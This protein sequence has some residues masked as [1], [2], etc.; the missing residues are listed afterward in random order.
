[1]AQ[2]SRTG[3]VRTVSSPG[4]KL[5][6]RTLSQFALL[7][8]TLEA[9]RA[10]GCSPVSSTTGHCLGPSAVWSQMSEKILHL[11]TR[12][13]LFHLVEHLSTRS[14]PVQHFRASQ[15]SRQLHQAAHSQP[16]QSVG[17]VSGMVMVAFRFTPVERSV[18]RQR[19]CVGY[20]SACGNQEWLVCCY[21]RI[22]QIHSRRTNTLGT[23]LGSFHQQRNQTL[24]LV[25]YPLESD[26]KVVASV[27]SSS[28]KPSRSGPGKDFK[29]FTAEVARDIV[30]MTREHRKKDEGQ[31]HYASTHE[32]L[33]EPHLSAYRKCRLSCLSVLVLCTALKE[34]LEGRMEERR[35]WCRR[36]G[37]SAHT[38]APGMCTCNTL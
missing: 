36:A 5:R 35:W 22:S 1:M 23:S 13:R 32:P 33:L 31:T 9:A 15:C 30:V 24:P 10:F 12:S 21:G 8:S 16:Q 20:V 3:P 19:R 37:H 17:R 14:G 25:T 2:Q 4:A 27:S 26:L 11:A 38:R 34:T 6:P 18:V 29:V 28:A 7:Q